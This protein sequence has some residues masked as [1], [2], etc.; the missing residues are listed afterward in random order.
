M[1][2]VHIIW[3][4]AHSTD[5]WTDE[6]D[7]SPC[8]CETI[9]LLVKETETGIS[10]SHTKQIE[11]DAYCCLIHIP[12]SCIKKLTYLKAVADGERKEA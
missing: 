11:Y 4:D 10:V 1:N 2:L 8:L 5:A 9:G 12:K 7:S 3:E 6:I